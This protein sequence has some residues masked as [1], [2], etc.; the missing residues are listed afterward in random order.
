MFQHVLVPLDSS[1]LSD[2]L[3]QYAAGFGR[4]FNAQITLLRAY[5]WSERYAMV[6]TPVLEVAAGAERKEAAAARVYLE[7]RA[8]SLRD[9]GLLVETVVVDAPPAQAILSEATRKPDTLVVLGTRE[10]RWI[11]RLLRGGTLHEVLKDF[12]VPVLVVHEHR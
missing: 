11:T 1:P 6:D 10:R 5:N 12:H 3:L 4:A 8:Q 7:E 2:H 9:A